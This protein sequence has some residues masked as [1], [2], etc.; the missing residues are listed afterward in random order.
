[1]ILKNSSVLCLYFLTVSHTSKGVMKIWG[2]RYLSKNTVI[3]L[4]TVMVEQSL[5]GYLNMQMFRADLADF[6]NRAST[7]IPDNILNVINKVVYCDQEI[8]SH[9]GTVLGL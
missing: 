1:M 5:S 9:F 6:S 8:Y 7:V 3:Y 4:C 2:V